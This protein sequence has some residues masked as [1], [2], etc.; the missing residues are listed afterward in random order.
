MVEPVKSS[1]THRYIG[2]FQ[3]FKGKLNTMG[4]VSINIHH[5]T[6]SKSLQ[7]LLYIG[8]DTQRGEE[9]HRI[10]VQTKLETPTSGFFS[11]KCEKPEETI[12]IENT[13][14]QETSWW[15]IWN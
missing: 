7:K 10:P 14:S 4:G 1:K 6:N 2:I 5:Y 13:P 3:L 12:D 15:M 8:W 11:Y 9:N